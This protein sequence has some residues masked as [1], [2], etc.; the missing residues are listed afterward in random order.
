[1][2]RTLIALAALATSIAIQPA[3]AQAG[4]ADFLRSLEGSWSGGGPVRMRPSSSPLNVSCSISTDATDTSLSL[5]GSCTGL[6]VFTRRIGA[7]LRF[8]GGTYSGTYD[9]SPRGTA[10][11]AGNRSGRTL[12][13]ALDWPN[14]PTASM[15]LASPDANRMVLTTIETHPDTGEQVVTAELELTRD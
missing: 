14:R 13:L 11:L 1:M 6:A 5:D 3:V 4:E 8:N 9:G 10:S 2:K 12:E 7:E 15:R